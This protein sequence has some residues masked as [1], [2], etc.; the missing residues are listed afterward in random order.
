M[1]GQNLNGRG[2]YGVLGQSAGG[3]VVRGGHRRTGCWHSQP[4]ATTTCKLPITTRK[5]PGSYPKPPG[6]YEE[7]VGTT[8]SARDNLWEGFTPTFLPHLLHVLP[9]WIV[10]QASAATATADGARHMLPALAHG[11]EILS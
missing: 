2:A 4:H 8:E 6:S 10:L 9:M 1:S 5:L 3:W 11:V 7:A